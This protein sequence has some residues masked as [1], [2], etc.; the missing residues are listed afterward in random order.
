MVLETRGHRLAAL[1]GVFLFASATYAIVERSSERNLDR[2]QARL[3]AAVVP[4]IREAEYVDPFAGRDATTLG[5]FVKI[6]RDSAGGF[7]LSYDISN[8][9][10][11]RCVTV[12]R[13]SD[14]TVEVNATEGLCHS[15]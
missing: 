10:K 4:R 7:T 2:Q 5:P 6:A 1:V 13:A 9:W 15:R 8:W 14:G 3:E 11:S 12:S